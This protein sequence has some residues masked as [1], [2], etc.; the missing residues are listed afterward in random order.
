MSTRTDTPFPTA[1]LFRFAFDD[2]GRSCN[3]ADGDPTTIADYVL[4]CA[5][6]L[7]RP[8]PP[9]IAMS[10]AHAALTPAM[11]SFIEESKRLLTRRLR[12]ELRFTPQYPNLAAGLPS[13]LSS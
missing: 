10:Q 13:C 9:R 6:L 11:M 7:D 8:P 4:R 12:E 1:P 3:I 5:A 2:S